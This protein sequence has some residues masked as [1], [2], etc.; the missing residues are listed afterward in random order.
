MSMAS[1]MV[2]LIIDQRCLM[3]R[4]FTNKSSEDR[5]KIGVLEAIQTSNGEGKE[6]HQPLNEMGQNT[7]HTSSAQGL[8]RAHTNSSQPCQ[9][10]QTQ[11]AA[12]ASYTW[13]VARRM[14]AHI[15]TP[16]PTRS[17]P[18]TTDGRD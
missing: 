12:W 14:P 6:P 1:F 5:E 17:R 8:A 18:I 16:K 11:R 2:T 13:H 4:L 10:L 15:H 9:A 7:P 3:R